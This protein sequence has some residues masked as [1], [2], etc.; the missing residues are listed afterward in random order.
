MFELFEHTADVGLRVRAAS[1]DLLFADA[2]RA[3]S[4]M[5]VQDL[6]AILPKQ[7]H[8][9]QLDGGGDLADLMVDWLNELLYLFETRR[10]IFSHF[11]VSVEGGSLCA[12]VRG[13]TLDPAQHAADTAIKAVT[14]HHLKVEQDDKG[15]LAEVILDL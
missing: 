6:H 1:L 15:W 13:E 12:Q 8:T 7:P 14:Y 9:I 11:E 10:L 4:S 5:L 2:G 3:L